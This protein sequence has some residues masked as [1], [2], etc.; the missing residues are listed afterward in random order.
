[1]RWGAAQR[2]PGAAACLLQRGGGVNGAGRGRC[3]FFIRLV[4]FVL[5]PPHPAARG[6]S[7]REPAWRGPSTPSL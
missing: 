1:M 6:S 2:L 4:L 3:V 7:P 5:P